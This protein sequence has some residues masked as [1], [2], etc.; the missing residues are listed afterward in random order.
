MLPYIF[1]IEDD[2]DIQEYLKD[3]LT[4]N[5]F[6]V[7]TASTGTSGLSLI[8][9]KEPDLILLDL[10]LPDIGGESVC[11]QIRESYPNLP[12]I[13]L[14]SNDS[15]PDKVKVLGIGADDYMTKPFEISELVARIHARTRNASPTQTILK[16]EDLEMDTQKIE[17]RRSGKNLSL[18]PQEF[19]LLEYL[20][21]NRGRVLTREA[22][23]NRLW[24]LSPDIE[25]RVV[26]VYIGYLRKKVDTGFSKK[27][28]RSIR[29]FGYTIGS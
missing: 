15:L 6:L 18:T 3:Q 21:A 19:K 27:L 8:K 20:M 5:N 24:L 26:D 16:V 17:V 29:G 22:I 25:S 7:K 28:I 4:L 23:L 1:V 9:K 11:Q 10:K 14:S 13:I 2:P 12:I